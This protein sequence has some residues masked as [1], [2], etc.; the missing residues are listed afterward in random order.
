MTQIVIKP[1]YPTYKATDKVLFNDG[2]FLDTIDEHSPR[3]ILSILDTA[4]VAIVSDG[5]YYPV[6]KNTYKEQF[7]LV[8]AG[9]EP[10]V[11]E[12]S[13]FGV[14]KI[15]SFITATK[16]EV[17]DKIQEC[18]I[19]NG[20]I[21]GKLLKVTNYTALDCNGIT[22]N[23]YWLAFD[24]DK[25]GAE[26][27][28]Y[29]NASILLGK[30]L[31][32]GTNYFY[33]GE[34]DSH[35]TSTIIAITSTLTV[36][37]ESGENMAIFENSLYG[38]VLIANDDIPAI[39]VN[40]T[41]YDN[42]AD[43][44]AN[45]NGEEI[46]INKSITIPKTLTLDNEKN[47]SINLVNNVTV[48]VNG[49]IMIKS[50]C[51]MIKGD[52]TIKE[53]KAYLAPIILKNDNEKKTASCFIGN[54]ITLW[55]WA[56]LMYDGKSVNLDCTCLAHLIGNNDGSDDGAGFYCNGNVKDGHFFFGGS[57][58]NTTGHAMYIAG[59]INTI[60][61]NAELEGTTSGVEVRAGSLEI[62]HSKITSINTNEPSMTANGSGTTSDS[63]ALAVAQHT[64]KK[65][66]TVSV[67]NTTLTGVGAFMEGNPQ[68]NPDCTNQMNIS[69]GE[70]TT[71][72]GKV[73]TL[74]HENDCK[75]FIK[76]NARCSIEPD[77]MYIDKNCTT[78][79]NFTGTFE[80][81][82]K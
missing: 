42:L 53:A 3:H 6:D 63:V 71:L 23:G 13:K 80:I 9:K 35:I 79:Q 70:G 14:K 5:K 21:F 2:N 39:T 18:S 37:G 25:S 78:E 36:D 15:E 74:D 19:Y 59:N 24:Y 1:K 31:V 58:L 64:T 61:T 26:A 8:E 30:E 51:L 55:G 47:V 28:G 44:I 66:I 17:A 75:N 12:D 43:A 50:G 62:Y 41:G 60:I 67:T 57:T 49:Y 46:K 22:K 29:S 27:E 20:I 33:F 72:N 38:Q 34:D 7:E 76:E 4:H 40:C 48:T 56:G 54:G 52:G 11:K 81:I 10:T 32:D 65:D 73:L 69:L 82:K 16:S 68:K 77:E 45:A